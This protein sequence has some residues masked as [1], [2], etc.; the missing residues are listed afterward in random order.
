MMLPTWP[1]R[2]HK[3]MVVN[4]CHWTKLECKLCDLCDE[5][6]VGSHAPNIQLPIRMLHVWVTTTGWQ[7]CIFNLILL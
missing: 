6:K 3:P 5:N 1:S 2:D 7:L 4:T